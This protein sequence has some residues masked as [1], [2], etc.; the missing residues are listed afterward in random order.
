MFGQVPLTEAFVRG[1]RELTAKHGVLLIFDEVVTGFRVSRGGAQ[2][3]FGIRP[4]LTTFAKILAGGLPGAAVAGRREILEL[5]DFK[6]T[7]ATG[8]EKVGHPG[9]YNANPVSAAAG[10]ACLTELAETD[11]NDV[12]SA[13]AAELRAGLNEMLAEEKLPW[14]AYGFTSGFHLFTNPKGREMR[15]Q[16]FDA[17]T[18]PP[19]ELKGGAR[20]LVN[21]MRLALLVNGVDSNGRLGGFLSA[22]H[23]ATDVADTVAAYRAAIRMLR[24]EGEL[25]A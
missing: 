23:T 14:A 10:I 6:A 19:D 20:S 15:P 2:A 12:A 1:L 8:R 21:R 13:R 22:T 11:A 16:S 24:A 7:A 9:T 5:L 4:D 17:D 18:C 25:P 3:A